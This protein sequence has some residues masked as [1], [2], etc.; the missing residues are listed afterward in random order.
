MLSILDEF[1][2]ETGAF[3]AHFSW[4]TLE[5]LQQEARTNTKL[6]SRTPP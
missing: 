5:E 6:V 4:A 1:E 2:R 3:Q